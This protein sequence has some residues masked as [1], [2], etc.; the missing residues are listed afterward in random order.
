MHF[1]DN[2]HGR[3]S[4]QLMLSGVVPVQAKTVEMMKSFE[5]S[6]IFAKIGF[7]TTL[8][9][10]LFLI[11]ATVCHMRR[12]DFTY[13]TMISFFGLTGLIFSGWELIS[14]P[15]MHNFND[16]M[17]FF[18]LRTTVSQKF[19]QFS[20]AFHAA[21]CEAMIAM[22]SIQFVYRYFSL[23]RPDY[24]KDD[25]KGTVFWLLYPVVPG[26]M[27]FCSFY[28]YC[29][30]DQFTDA[31]LRT[32]M[33]SSYGLQIIDIPRFI[34]VSYVIVSCIRLAK[35]AE[36]FQNTDDT[37]RWKN[38]VFLIQGSVIL[39]FH[40]LLILFYGIK[41]HF[42]LKKK[43][44]EFSVTTTRLHKQVFRALVVQI[45]IPTVIFILP[46]V[47]IFFGPLL[48]PL[49][50]IPISLRSG[51]LCS[52]FSVYPVAD[53][54]AFMLIVSEYKKI[55]AVK[56]IGVFAPTATFSAQSFTVDP[57]VHPM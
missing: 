7:F 25:G 18:S 32:E 30:P 45:L 21:I 43:L 49:L 1:D 57:R 47:P 16:S 50:G 24:R 22:I 39:G 13:R 44:N 55:F 12:L 14:K 35:I 51:W 19:F 33:L 10:N 52:I 40:Y 5:F 48:S 15:F 46:S 6:F 38:M 9:T 53:S 54:L 20:I 2:P 26:V 28:I 17:I 8:F 42:H 31:Y 34:I 3:W 4:V 27:Y 41:M 11:Y 23:L 29:M 56:L 36:S 37:I